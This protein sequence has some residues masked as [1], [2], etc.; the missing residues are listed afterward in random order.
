MKNDGK[1]LMR[2]LGEHGLVLDRVKKSHHILVNDE[3]PTPYKTVSVPVHG[4]E[5]VSKRTERTILKQT[6]L[7]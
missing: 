1:E 6:G 5:V 3:S 7:L 2:L 4:S